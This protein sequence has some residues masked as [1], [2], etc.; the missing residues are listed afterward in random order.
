MEGDFVANFKLGTKTFGPIKGVLPAE[1][2][3]AAAR[4]RAIFDF[5]LV[6]GAILTRCRKT[7]FLTKKLRK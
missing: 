6:K 3:V 5:L 2:G 7:F 1:S 4:R